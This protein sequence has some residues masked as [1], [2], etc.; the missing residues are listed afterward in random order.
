MLCSCSSRR[1]GMRSMPRV[2]AK[3]CRRLRR[4]PCSSSFSTS[5][6][7][8]YWST[9]KM[10]AK[11]ISELRVT[12]RLAFGTAHVRL[13][14]THKLHISSITLADSAFLTLAISISSHLF[15]CSISLF[16]FASSS[17]RLRS[18]SHFFF[19]SAL[20]SPRL[21]GLRVWFGAP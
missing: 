18:S 4:L 1:K 9:A 17:R 10:S 12:Y 13:V 16:F 7:G 3:Q 21:C 11:L 19:L 8:S 2:S 20:Y 15:F 14:L 6:L 5:S